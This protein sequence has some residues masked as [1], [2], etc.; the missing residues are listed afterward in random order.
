MRV[1]EIY[2]CDPETGPLPY[3]AG[4]GLLL[5]DRTVL[6]ANHL[7]P[8]G[9]VLVRFPGA[10][11]NTCHPAEVRWR[12]EE[13]DAAVLHIP[14]GD[15]VPPNLPGL[16]WGRFVT[17]MSGV[18]AEVAGF[19]DAH[20]GIRDWAQAVGSLEEDDER[21][22]VHV[23][24][25]LR[26]GGR[27]LW[28][29]MA[30]AG[31]FSESL[32]AGLIVED[33]PEE[34]SRRLIA[35]PVEALLADAGFAAAVWGDGGAP[36]LEPVEVAGLRSRPVPVRVSPA[37]LLRAEAEVVP[38]HGREE[39]LGRLRDWL[40]G[41]D[42]A[43][44]VLT[45]PGGQGK[46]R[47]A[48]E[49]AREAGRA[50][51]LVVELR[52]DAP[53]GLFERLRD[54]REPLLV[55]VDEADKQ[56]ER[57]ER[58]VGELPEQQRVR[59][60]LVARTGGDWLHELAL[61]SDPFAALLPGDDLG[62]VTERLGPL[63]A[64]PTTFRRAVTAFGQ[65]LGVASR[66]S[67]EVPSL[68]DDRYGNVLAVHMEAM[69]RLMNAVDPVPGDDAVQVLLEHETRY[70]LRRARTTYELGGLDAAVLRQTVAVA[71]LCTVR[72][73]PGERL[74]DLLE[75]V[76]LLDDQPPAVK[77]AAAQ[78]LSDFYGEPGWQCAALRPRPLHEHLV[79]VELAAD[80]RML[81]RV[82][83]ILTERQA[84]ELLTVLARAG[85]ET[86]AWVI[87]TLVRRY[88]KRLAYPAWFAAG[89]VDEAAAQPLHAA[90]DAIYDGE[91]ARGRRFRQS[92]SDATVAVGIALSRLRRGTPEQPKPD[93]ESLRPRPERPV[94][95]GV[96]AEVGA[97]SSAGA[98]VPVAVPSSPRRSR[99]LP[100]NWL[101]LPSPAWAGRSLMT[102]ARRCSPAWI[103]SWLVAL[104]RRRSPVWAARSLVAW[105]RRCSPVRAGR[106]LVAWVRRS[107][108]AWVGRPS[109]ARGRRPLLG[110]FRLTSPSWVRRPSPGWVR[111]PS[112]GWVRRPSPGWVR[113]PS[114][115]WVRRPAPG[116]VRRGVLRLP[117]VGSVVRLVR[118][119]PGPARGIAVGAAVVALAS[120]LLA[121][122]PES[123]A[124]EP[125]V[126][127]AEGAAAAPPVPEPPAS[128]GE[129]AFVP[130]PTP[131]RS[132]TGT[133]LPKRD[134]VVGPKR[135]EGR[136]GRRA[137]SPSAD[138]PSADS[139]SAGRQPVRTAAQ[140]GRTA[141]PP[142]RTA[143]P[144]APAVTS[145]PRPTRSPLPTV[146]RTPVGGPQTPTDIPTLTGLPTLPGRMAPAYSIAQ[147]DPADPA[148]PA[149]TSGSDNAPDTDIPPEPDIAP[150]GDDADGP[151]DMFTPDDGSTADGVAD[152]D[153]GPDVGATSGSAT[154]DDESVADDGSAW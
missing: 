150:A 47:L 88:P 117:V 104:V 31:L 123:E 8:T 43:V 90:L 6:T 77:A 28:K 145:R 92:L 152:G 89:L 140:P 66:A 110:R 42:A 21:I 103:G 44:R 72:R 13:L 53:G 35:V 136:S 57:L 17:G 29:G 62:A 153:G 51:W 12:S 112:P 1:C 39:E 68:G 52:E 19:P 154:S 116:W 73:G 121:I 56:R 69:A 84:C 149:D 132:N 76:P 83:P 61:E 134:Q 45:G 58:L 11:E 63:D 87:D 26:P 30:G 99:R 105:L 27:T 122:I 5:T 93:S 7:L 4:S 16:R 86:A 118:E 18:R 10:D 131:T 79:A 102:W 148:D 130:S 135:T 111:R 146:T 60:L 139:P 46:T 37:G 20:G 24:S 91:A 113:R 144:K 55:V 14:D 9:D 59:L 50:G 15:W 82:V 25:W 142:V 114:P 54:V 129:P 23:E 81:D 151:D 32:L 65:R 124:G 107:S 40:D 147:P 2:T 115:G 48:R 126:A 120:P 127:P 128:I 94:V 3:P 74:S 109:A 97:R 49:F 78:W 96:L 125:G 22:A 143:A 34:R 98:L 41:G 70:W 80:P 100:L 108:S 138:S 64:W 67:I 101:R 33:P 133:A 141:A 95:P 38:F 36:A 85:G 75:R 106:S 137:D 119:N 71:T